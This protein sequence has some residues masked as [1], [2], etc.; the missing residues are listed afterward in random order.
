[1]I[2]KASTLGNTML[3]STIQMTDAERPLMQRVNG[4]AEVH[5]D[6]GGLV[7]L[8]QRGSAKAMLPR[9]HGDRPEIVFLNTAGGVTGGDRL[10]YDLRIGSGASAVATT[11]TAERAYASNSGAADV[12]IRVNVDAGGA[13]DWLPQ[14]TILFDRAQLDRTSEI[15]LASDARLLYCETLVLGRAAMGEV[16]TDLR[17]QDNRMIRRAGKPL[18]FDPVLI[19]GDMLGDAGQPALLGDA[20]AVATVV[21]AEQGAEDALSALR[22]IL[23]GAN[24]RAAASAWNGKCVIRLMAQD[25]WPLRQTLKQVLS[26]LRGGELPRVW[27]L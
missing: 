27:Q 14:E 26:H 23:A 18:L 13:L 19:T 17:L 15:E 12:S 10:H 21:L 5:L 2:Y 7:H 22:D 4:R 11:Q 16:V 25:A 9:V 6:A 24:C 8:H 20:R 1:V 3:Q